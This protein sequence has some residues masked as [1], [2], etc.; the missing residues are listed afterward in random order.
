MQPI[1]SILLIAWWTIQDFYQKEF[2]KPATTDVLTQ[3]WHELMHAIWWLILDDELI[4]AY[5][6]SEKDA[7]SLTQENII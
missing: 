3:L 5:E 4:D 6:N 1:T 2:G 7:L